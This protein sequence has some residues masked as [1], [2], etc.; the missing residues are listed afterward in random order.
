MGYK[1][2]I[3][4]HRRHRVEIQTLLDKMDIYCTPYGINDDL[5]FMWGGFITEHSFIASNDKFRDH[6]FKTKQAKQAKQAKQTKQKITQTQIED[7]LH[8]KK[9]LDQIMI[10]YTMKSKTSLNFE[11]PVKVTRCIQRNNG[12][13][14]IPFESGEWQCIF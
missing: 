10:T 5:F 1:P 14:H 8:F 12:H 2:L 6:I 9:Y 7:N 11:F 13:W 3:I 4:I